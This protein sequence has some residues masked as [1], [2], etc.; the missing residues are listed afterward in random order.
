MANINLHSYLW[1]TVYTNIKQVYISIES[2]IVSVQNED[3]VL[4]KHIFNQIKRRNTC[5][6]SNR[7][8]KNL[9]IRLNT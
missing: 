6:C 3:G 1:I 8:L 4:M 2:Y 7:N 5:F 9:Q